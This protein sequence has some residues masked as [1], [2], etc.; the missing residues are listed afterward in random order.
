MPRPR[1]RSVTSTAYVDASH[2]A[3]KVTRIF[4]SGYIL[5]LNRSPIKWMIKRQHTVE[6]SSF[7]SEF[8]SLKQC[9]EDIENLR[10]KLRTFGIPLSE[11]QPDTLILFNNEAVCKKK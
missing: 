4:H 6:T 10:S 1:V 3:N 7:S 9:I 11:D 8:I 2:G 5:F